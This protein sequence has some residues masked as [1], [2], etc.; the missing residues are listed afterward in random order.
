M[1]VAVYTIAKNEA[2]HAERWA[3]SAADAD[4]LIVADTGSTDET[5][6]RLTGRRDGAP[7]RGSPLAVR[8]CAQRGACADPGRRRR[9]LHH[10]HGQ[11]SG[12]RLAAETQ[13]GVES[14]DDR[15]L[16]PSF[17]RAPTIRRLYKTYPSK[18]FHRR[19]GYRFKRGYTRLCS[20]PARS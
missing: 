6:E 12:A 11:V 15:A 16:L 1:K 18:S 7:Y 8:R 5:A 2:A 10:G 17:D 20:L 3:N 13:G 19:W 14:R 4:Y 9:L